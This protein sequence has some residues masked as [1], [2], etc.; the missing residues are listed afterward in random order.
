MAIGGNVIIRVRP[1]VLVQKS[2]EVSADI[3]KLSACF[4]DLERI[5]NR[6]SYYW[7]GEAGDMHRKLYQEQKADVD[8]MMRR[9]KEH[10]RDLLEIAQKYIDVD[11]AAGAMANELPG[12]VIE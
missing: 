5:V 2:Q 4:E 11:V 3:Q 6:T 8:E 7:V 10:P 1:E 9:L 12:D